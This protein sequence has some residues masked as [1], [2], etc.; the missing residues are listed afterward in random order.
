MATR[1]I[2]LT[3]SGTQISGQGPIVDVDFNGTNLDADI[4]VSAVYGTSTIVKEYT[5]DIDAGTY[6]LEID[7]KNDEGG[8]VDRNLVIEKIEF[9]NDGSNYTNFIVADSNSNL[10]EGKHFDRMGYFLQP[11]ESYDP[12]QPRSDSNDKWILN[13]DF[14]I[15]LPRTDDTNTG[16]VES[17]LSNPGNNP[18]RLYTLEIKPIKIYTNNTATFNITFS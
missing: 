2:R 15:S 14:D 4:D 13:P 5:V 8:D 3:M 17:N 6:N 1:K 12:A 10:E 9:A 11:N 16:Y 7:F 18:K